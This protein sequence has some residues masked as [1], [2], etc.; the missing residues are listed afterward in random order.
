MQKRAGLSGVGFRFPKGSHDK[1]GL[2]WT[3]KLNSV[4]LNVNFIS[5]KATVITFLLYSTFLETED[6]CLQ[7]KSCVLMTHFKRSNRQLCHIEKTSNLLEVHSASGYQ[8]LTDSS[9]GFW[10]ALATTQNWSGNAHFS[11][12]TS[13]WQ[14]VAKWS[15]DPCDWGEA[16]YHRWLCTCVVLVL[17]FRDE[18]VCVD[19]ICSFFHLLDAAILQAVFNVVSQ[20]AR[21]QHGILGNQGYLHEERI[22]VVSPFKQLK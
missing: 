1:L 21:E 4:R 5:L 11:T 2:L 13:G 17:H 19:I 7:N 9:L 20:G 15:L 8:G 16:Q 6:I 10:L 18:V 3:N 12:V 22:N 14:T